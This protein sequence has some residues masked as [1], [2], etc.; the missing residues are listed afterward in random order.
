MEKSYPEALRN[1]QK[2]KNK[3][4]EAQ[5]KKRPI[6]GEKIPIGTKVLISIPGIIQNKLHPKYRG[7]F[8]VIGLTKND[9]YIIP[10]HGSD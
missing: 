6:T 8:T 2:G 10:F 4:V 9:N 5:N 1:I 3:Q 7:P